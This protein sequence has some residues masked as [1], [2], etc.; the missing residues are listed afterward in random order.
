MGSGEC[1][2]FDAFHLCILL[3]GSLLKLGS[4]GLL[5]GLSCL[6]SCLGK[7]ESG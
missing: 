3:L 7:R 2:G 5:V 4:R 6:I 1:H